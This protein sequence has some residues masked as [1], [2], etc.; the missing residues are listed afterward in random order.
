MISGVFFAATGKLLPFPLLHCSVQ[1]H[2]PLDR[3][4]HR[5]LPMLR[6]TK[7]DTKRPPNPPWSAKLL[8]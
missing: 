8:P 2:S 6:E 7:R 3:P 1:V 4:H 5:T